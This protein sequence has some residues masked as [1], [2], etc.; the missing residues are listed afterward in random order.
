MLYNIV[1]MRQIEQI[2]KVHTRY[3]REIRVEITKTKNKYKSS[4]SMI[5]MLEEWIKQLSIALDK[6]VHGEQLTE[7]E[8][9]AVASII[10]ATI[11]YLDNFDK[12]NDE[13]KEIE[14]KC[15]KKLEEVQK[16][17]TDLH[18]QLEEKEEEVD[19]KLKTLDN[20]V[21]I[22]ESNPRLLPKN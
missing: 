10:Y 6:F 9:I 2:N 20:L 1:L 12:C 14:E 5:I 13:L 16:E 22:I 11:K 7:D 19:E 8:R 17:L 15:K 21:K 4:T 18:K 3:R